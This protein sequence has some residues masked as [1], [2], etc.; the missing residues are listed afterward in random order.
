MLFNVIYTGG[1]FFH[2]YSHHILII[3]L[4]EIVDKAAIVDDDPAILDH[5]ADRRSQQSP[6]KFGGCL[7]GSTAVK[8]VPTND[9]VPWRWPEP[10]MVHVNMIKSIVKPYVNIIVINFVIS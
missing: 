4:I 3:I 6:R 9:L 7:P 5:P 2:S 8:S 10:G 1:Y